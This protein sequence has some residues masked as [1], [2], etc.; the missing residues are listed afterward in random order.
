M[1]LPTNLKD[2]QTEAVVDVFFL[3]PTIFTGKPKNIQKLGIVPILI[4][5]TQIFIKK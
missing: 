1:K 3:Y 4:F 5:F 2:G